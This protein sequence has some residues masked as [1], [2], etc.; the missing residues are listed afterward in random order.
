[1]KK[2]KAQKKNVNE[3]TYRVNEQDKI[4]WQQDKA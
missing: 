3:L 4:G 2:V 1:M